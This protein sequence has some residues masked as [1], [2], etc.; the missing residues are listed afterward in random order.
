MRKTAFL[1][2]LLLGASAADAQLPFLRKRSGQRSTETSSP[3]GSGSRRAATGRATVTAR[4]S[5]V[6]KL[7]PTV[8]R[9][10]SPR[11]RTNP[12]VSDSE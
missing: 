5:T 9:M 1:L 3:A 2:A 10:A 12:R 4:A 6:T 7:P 8:S 11:R